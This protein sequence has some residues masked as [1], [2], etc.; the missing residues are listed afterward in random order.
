MIIQLSCQDRPGIV[1]RITGHIH[2]VNG[3]ILTLEQHVE[4]EENLYFM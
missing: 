2:A 3:N 1:A 4:P